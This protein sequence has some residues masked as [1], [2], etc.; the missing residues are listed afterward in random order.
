VLGDHAIAE[1]LRIEPPGGYAGTV[2]LAC[3]QVNELIGEPASAEAAILSDS[4]QMAGSSVAYV[5][6]TSEQL[7]FGYA[8][9]VSRPMRA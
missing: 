5:V 6:C 3:H 1:R 4:P 9:C 7:I 2:M 8:G